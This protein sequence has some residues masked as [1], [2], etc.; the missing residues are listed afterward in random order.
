MGNRT[1]R[2]SFTVPSLQREN[3][4]RQQ[5]GWSCG[6]YGNDPGGRGLLPVVA[7][8]MLDTPPDDLEGKD[9]MQDVLGPVG[10]MVADNM[11]SSSCAAVLKLPPCAARIHH[12]FGFRTGVS[13]PGSGGD[14]CLYPCYRNVPG[15]RGI[16]GHR[17]KP[18]HPGRRHHA[19]TAATVYLGSGGGTDPKKAVISGT[20]PAGTQSAMPCFQTKV[21]LVMRPSVTICFI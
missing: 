5:T 10:H 16:I 7:G 17:I 21:S 1:F 6:G 2:N 18:D 4:D 8:S 12:G 19:D 3:S 9:D 11:K 13:L 20:W 14:V 15:V